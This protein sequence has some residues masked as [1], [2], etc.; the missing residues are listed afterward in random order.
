MNDL[1]KYIK[2]KST[3]NISR[4]SGIP[5]S[6]IRLKISG[7]KINSCMINTKMYDSNLKTYKIL[8]TNYLANGGDDMVF[9]KIVKLYLIPIAF[10]KRCNY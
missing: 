9:L 8:T 3:T 2:D 5:V 7:D 1:I 4:K 6:G 10:A